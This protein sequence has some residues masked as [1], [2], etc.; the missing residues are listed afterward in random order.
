MK[1]SSRRSGFNAILAS[2]I[3]AAAL[4]CAPTVN[5]GELPQAS[6]GGTST[7]TGGGSSG[8]PSLSGTACSVVTTLAS[9]LNFPASMAIFGDTLY[10]VT[11][12]PQGTPEGTGLVLSVPI[13]GGTPVVLAS[14]QLH[15][16][17]I[18]ASASRVYWSS[19]DEVKTMP[20]GGGPVTLIAGGQSSAGSIVLDATS[21]YR[22]NRGDGRIMKAPL[23]GGD[24]TTLFSPGSSGVIGS[25]NLALDAENV[26]WSATGEQLGSGSVMKAPIDGG[27][28]TTLASGLSSW[29]AVAVDATNIYWTD[30]VTLHA[31]N[32]Q[33]PGKVT[34]LALD[35]SSA[36]VTL[37]TQ[38]F[39]QAL[40]VDGT[41]VYWGGGVVD[42]TD[43]DLI[44]PTFITRGSSSGA[45]PTTIV[46]TVIEDAGLV[47]CPNGVCWTDAVQGK[48]MRFEACAP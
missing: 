41:S 22:G 10:V 16:Q 24:A 27:A 15:P 33:G 21:V 3:S 7:G 44:W 28:A 36:A 6:S 23:S 18:A 47:A 31:D 42:S 26:Y 34:K 11:D 20:V 37:A 8:D 48:V 9:G 46:D 1:S 35:G 19:G 12:D 39:P 29:G 17:G 30:D 5:L 14:N 45:A 13:T 38:R 43:T 4:G 2:L 40:A 25:L 32:T